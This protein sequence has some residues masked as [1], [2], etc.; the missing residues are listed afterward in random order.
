MASI[1]SFASEF[2]AAAGTS[3]NDAGF[4]GYQRLIRQ[5]ENLSLISVWWLVGFGLAF[6]VLIVLSVIVRPKWWLF[7]F[8]PLTLACLIVGAVFAVNYHYTLYRTLGDALQVPKY[9]TATPAA[10]QNAEAGKYPRGVVVQ[11]SIDGTASGLGSLPADVYLPPQYFDHPDEKFPVIYLYHGIPD[12]APPGTPDYGGPASLFTSAMSD[13]AALV[14]AQQGHPV[15]LV[16]P[17]VSPLTADTEC[18]DGVAGKWQTYLSV[19]VPAWVAKQPRLQTGPANTGMGGYS[20]GGF[21]AQVGALRN[22]DKVSVVGNMSGYNQPTPPKSAGQASLF[23]NVA[24]LEALV[25]TYNSIHIVETSPASHSVTVWM[26]IG[27]SD[28]PA[29]LAAQQQFADT[30]RAAGMYVV[31]NQVSG[32]VHGFDTWAQ[33]FSDWIPW[34][35]EILHRPEGARSTSGSG[36]N[37]QPSTSTRAPTAARP[38]AGS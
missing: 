34:A 36:A 7:L 11:E 29:L 30:A 15:V 37:P 13:D 33:A 22:P 35:A 23:G 17:V 8:I 3:P 14:A 32:G 12:V 38:K 31:T 6:I 24:N 5:F 18:V 1:Q 2:V 26:D 9:D 25:A 10:L 4:E 21:C 19:D 28:D 20:M 27:S 16:V